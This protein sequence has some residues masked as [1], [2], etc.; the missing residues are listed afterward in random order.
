M[1]SIGPPR[2][3]AVACFPTLGGS[4]IVATEVGCRLA[5]RGHEVRFFAAEPPARLEQGAARVSFRRVAVGSS[6]PEDAAAYPLALASALAEAVAKDGFDVIHAHYAIPHAAS[7][8]LARAIVSRTG[9]PLPRIVTTFHGTDVTVHGEGAAL[10]AVVRHVAAESDALSVPSAWLR[11]RATR[12]LGLGDRPVEVIR[13]FID[14]S[15]F[16][17]REGDLRELFPHLPGWGDPVRRPRVLF[18]GSSFR[19]LKRVGDAV[20]ALALIAKS[21][22]AALVLV[23]DGPERPAVEALASEL[24]VADR[25]R[26]LGLLPH[27]AGLLARADLFLLPSDTESFGLAALE[28]LACGV[29]VV[30]SAVGGLPEVVRDGE[31][32]LLVPPADPGALAGGC[33]ALLDDEARRRAFAAAARADALARFDPEPTIDRYEALLNPR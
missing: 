24:R 4:G 27:F 8:V 23:G 1:S 20:R 15:A 31:T 10:G 2:R 16:Q 12:C 3:I 22:G 6:L 30:A 28:A 19:P 25:V 17:P 29:P 18:H 13:N 11:D 26:F 14:A 32:G 33:L 9:G 5:A 21:R 7:A